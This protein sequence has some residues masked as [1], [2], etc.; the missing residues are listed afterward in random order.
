M[1]SPSRVVAW[2]A[3]VAGGAMVDV[4][5]SSSDLLQFLTSDASSNDSVRPPTAHRHLLI[6]FPGNP[7]LVQFYQPF[8][9]YLA[10]NGFDVLVMGY[11]GHSL[12]QH[13]K[14]RIFSL[15]EQIDIA[16]SFVVTLLNKNTELKYSSNIYIG[17]HSI[18]GFVALQ[19]AVR[20]SSI[21]KCFGLCPVISHMRESPN[22]RRLYYLGNAVAQWC[23]AGASA[24]LQLLPYR[25]R[26]HL[27]S[28]SEPRLSRALAEDLAHHF[29]RWSLMNSLYMAMTEFDMLLQPD[30]A[31]LRCVQE[32]LVLYYV[33]EDGW[34]PLPHAEEIRE[35]C[36]ELGAYVIEDDAEIT[37][38]WCLDQSE[39]VARN[40]ILKHC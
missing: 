10:A 27:I 9:A 1:L 35:I 31:L 28:R 12:T 32:R 21:K 26:L 8:C 40:A 17:G 39:A 14:G 16:D 36:P 34:A 11:A 4:L 7:G 23:L 33:K 2:K 37:H 3:P 29:H 18:G 30:A 19:M 20:Y 24:A 5:Q 13:N 38:A 6:F 22:G 25:L 15:T